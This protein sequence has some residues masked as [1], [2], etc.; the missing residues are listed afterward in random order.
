MTNFLS[1]RSA[2]LGRIITALFSLSLIFSPAVRGI[3]EAEAGR[4]ILI[5]AGGR[6]FSA[7]LYDNEAAVALAAMLPMRLEMGEL[8]GNEKYCG[9]SRSLPVN[10]ARPPGIRAGDLMLYGS[11]CLVLFYK[12]FSTTYSYTP[13]G[14]IDDPAGLAEALGC[15]KALVSFQSARE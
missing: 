10:P 13:L 5:N 14:R 8:N 2:V 3:A 12:S 11:D 7:T 15:G 4:Q 6:S 9:L 1:K